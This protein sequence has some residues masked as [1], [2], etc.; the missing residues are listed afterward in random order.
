MEEHCLLPS[1]QCL[2]SLFS[3]V[4]QD[5]LSG[6][7]LPT[8]GWGSPTLTKKVPTDTPTGQSHRDSSYIEVPSSQVTSLF[9]ADQN[10]PAQ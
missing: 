1:F 4:T 7:V 5:H 3:Y 9:Q 2:L 6:M 8:V 10:C